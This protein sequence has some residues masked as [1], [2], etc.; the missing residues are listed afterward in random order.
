M[1]YA[2]F[3]Y[4]DYQHNPKAY[5]AKLVS[6]LVEPEDYAEKILALPIQELN[7][8]VR[9]RKCTT[10]LNI[11]TVGDL[12]RHTAKDLLACRNFGRAS[13][14]EV[15]VSLAENIGYRLRGDNREIVAAAIEAYFAV[16]N[17]AG[18][19]QCNS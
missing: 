7:L 6:K 9:A 12:V 18:S 15:R 17:K 5:C 11:T 1:S 14:N 8:S 10:K 2:G 3:G 19:T 4:L 13:L 16:F